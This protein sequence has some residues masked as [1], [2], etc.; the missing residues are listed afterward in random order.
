[1]LNNY[2][3]PLQQCLNSAGRRTVV[4]DGQDFGLVAA[5]GSPVAE[6]GTAHQ[7]PQAQ[8][9][10]A[11]ALAVRSLPTAERPTSVISIGD[12]QTQHSPVRSPGLALERSVQLM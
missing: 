5:A 3:F 11:H 12:M 6:H 2:Q 8:D 7:Q 4:A 9:A 10:A 1:M